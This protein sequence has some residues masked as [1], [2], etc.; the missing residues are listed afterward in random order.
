MKERRPI[1]AAFCDHYLNKTVQSVIDVPVSRYE[2]TN[3]EIHKLYPG[4][5][6]P[7]IKI[8]IFMPGTFAVLD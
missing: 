6:K 3:I 2:W 8:I 5:H 1:L 4:T 7:V